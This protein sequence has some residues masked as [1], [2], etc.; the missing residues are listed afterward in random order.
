[1]VACP[2]ANQAEFGTGRRAR[3]HKLSR[4]SP[5]RSSL[6]PRLIYMVNM[7]ASRRAS[8][9]TYLLDSWSQ[10]SI[11]AERCPILANV[12]LRFN[13]RFRYQDLIKSNT[14]SRADGLAH[15]RESKSLPMKDPR[16]PLTTEEARSGYENVQRRSEAKYPVSPD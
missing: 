2:E 12:Q 4:L 15:H 5:C 11:G 9:G 13:R 7:L 8:F 14:D 1:M 6:L 10:E 16:I 3:R